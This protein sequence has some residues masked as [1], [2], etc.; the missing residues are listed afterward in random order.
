MGEV[1]QCLGEYDTALEYYERAL[2][3]YK[4]SLPS[5]HIEIAIVLVNK[6]SIKEEKADLQTA[7]PFYKKRLTFAL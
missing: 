6:G 1:Y 5:E 3:I 2:E 4:K 7:L